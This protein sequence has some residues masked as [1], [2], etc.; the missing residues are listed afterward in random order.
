MQ[1]QDGRCVAAGVVR[2]ERATVFPLVSCARS[3]RFKA[4]EGSGV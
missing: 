4:S 3:E 2:Q 1:L